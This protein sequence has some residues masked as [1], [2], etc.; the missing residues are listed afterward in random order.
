MQAQVSRLCM[1]VG[2]PVRA[3]INNLHRWQVVLY[4]EKSAY[5]YYEIVELR[6]TL[7]SEDGLPDDVDHRI[8]LHEGLALVQRKYRYRYGSDHIFILPLTAYTYR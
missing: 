1:G 7:S 5:R 8:D 6:E 2:E 3:R 4:G